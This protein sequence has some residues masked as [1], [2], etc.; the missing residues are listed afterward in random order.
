MD[1]VEEKEKEKEKEEKEEKEEGKPVPESVEWVQLRDPS[2]KTYYWNRRTSSTSW[3]PPASAIVVWVGER[4]AGEGGEVA[5]TSGTRTP[6][7]VGLTFLLFFLTDR[8]R[9]GGLGIPSPHLGCHS[10]CCCSSSCPP[11]S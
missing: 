7:P 3:N 6:L 9:G 2:G 1:V 4:N 8:R 5:S 10:S 11:C